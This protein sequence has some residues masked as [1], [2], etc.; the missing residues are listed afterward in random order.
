MNSAPLNILVAPL[1]WGLG[2]ATRSIPIIRA[3]LDRGHRVIIAS[4]GRALALLQKEFPQVTCIEVP[5]YDIQYQEKGSFVFKIIGQ[6]GKIFSG[7][8]REYRTTQ[9]IVREHNIQLIISDNRYGFYHKHVHSVIITHQMMVKLPQFKLGEPFIYLWLQRQHL[10]FD[11]VWIPD[12]QGEPNISGDLSHAYPILKRAQYIGILTRFMAQPENTPV[13]DQVLAIIS[14]PEPQRTLFEGAI[15]EQAKHINRS[16]I[17]VR[18][19]SEQNEDRMLTP[20]IRLISHMPGDALFTLIQQSS[21]IIS[22]GGYSTLMDLAVLHKKCIFVPTPGQTEQEYL[23][24]A[25]A[26]KKLVV[27]CAQPS[28]ELSRALADVA[29]TQGFHVYSKADAFTVY[30]DKAIALAQTTKNLTASS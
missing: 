12:V 21:I 24:R 19:L 25:L 10:R 26:A 22:R 29:D 13:Q 16:F 11:T 4:S 3:C 27:G 1:D 18:G 14:G 6:L 28:F 20:N 23:V 7:I 17:I 5:A 9:K 2:H 30:L 15:I 8:R